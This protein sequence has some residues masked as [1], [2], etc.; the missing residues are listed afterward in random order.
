MSKSLVTAGAIVAALAGGAGVAPQAAPRSAAAP[1]THAGPPPSTVD[2]KAVGDKYCVTCHNERLKRGNLVLEHLDPN[3][4]GDQTETWEKVV[5]K[6]HS[7]VMPPP[8]APR[9]D[10]DTCKGF[11]TAIE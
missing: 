11:V 10:S 7:G 1:T 2:T 3:A 5:K 9:P 6:L 4:P 8:G